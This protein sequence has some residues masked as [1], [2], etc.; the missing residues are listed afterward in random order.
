MQGCYVPKNIL[1]PSVPLA[2][3]SV[4]VCTNECLLSPSNS[5]AAIG[6]NCTCL[7]SL[8]GFNLANIAECN[9]KCTT[10]GEFCGNALNT[11]LSVYQLLA[12]SI[13]SGITLQTTPTSTTR[14]STDDN[15]IL[16]TGTNVNQRRIA[17]YISI[18]VVSLLLIALVIYCIRRKQKEASIPTLPRLHSSSKTRMIL[19]NLPETSDMVYSVQTPYTPRRSDEIPLNANDVVKV[20]DY[21][22][23]GWGYATNV[24]TGTQGLIPLVTLA[25]NDRNGVVT[26][27]S[28][29]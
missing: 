5:F 27:P 15:S 24:T 16:G 12:V 28:R 21:H 11:R 25:Q 26:I 13:P 23:N 22:P 8:D 6:T 17:L 14:P 19:P 1:P 2:S 4:D 18:A 20:G 3:L 7:P 9:Q 10:D 29:D